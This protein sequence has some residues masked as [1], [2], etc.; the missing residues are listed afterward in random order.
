MASF[1]AFSNG[2]IASPKLQEWIN[3][4][5]N[6]G[7]SKGLSGVGLRSHIRQYMNVN[8]GKYW[9]CAITRCYAF[10][11]QNPAADNAAEFEFNGE[12][13]IVFKSA[14]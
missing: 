1:V 4:A 5:I 10:T 9:H 6:T 11:N 13:W 2:D 3:E 12:G 14:W 7:I 8:H